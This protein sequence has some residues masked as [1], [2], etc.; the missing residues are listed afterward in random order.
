MKARAPYRF[1]PLSAKIHFPDWADQVS[2]DVPFPDGIVG[3]VDLK[4]VADTPLLVAQDTPRRDGSARGA[5]PVRSFVE[6]DGRVAIPGSTIRG[7]LRNVI[8]IASYGKMGPWIDD[9]RL[10]VRDLHN[11]ALYT[12][13]MTEKR[14]GGYRAKSRAAWLEIGPDGGWQLR[15]CAHARVRIEELEQLYHERRRRAV[16]LSSR[17]SSRSKYLRWGWLEHDLELRFDPTDDERQEE[18]GG[19]VFRRAMNLGTGA[20]VGQIVFTG[21]PSPRHNRK[22]KKR[23]FVFFDDGDEG[24][25]IAVTR[26]QQ[27]DFEWIHSQG[28]R[29]GEPQS[30][31]EWAFFKTHWLG[32]GR[33]VPVFFIP[34]AHGRLA[35]GLAQMFRLPYRLSLHEALD[36]TSTDHRRADPD[37]AELIFG[38]VRGERREALRGRVSFEPFWHD[39]Q[40]RRQRPVDTVLTGPKPSFYP[41]Y[42]SQKEAQGDQTP[43]YATLM[44]PDAELAGWKRYP[45]RPPSQVSPAPVRAGNE[46]VASRLEPLEPGATFMGRLH[47]H[48][49]RPAELGAVLW[50]ITWG[51]R[52]ELRHSLGLGKPFGYGQVRLEV[53][54][55]DLEHVKGTPVTSFDDLISCFTRH[56]EIAVGTWAASEPIAHLLGL[57]DPA[58]GAMVELTH[59]VLDD[60]TKLNE[61]VGIKKERR[62]LPP[63]VEFRGRT[64]RQVHPRRTRAQRERE[65]QEAHDA[66]RRQEEA[67]R[68]RHAALARAAADVARAARPPA[69]RFAEEAQSFD[70]GKA[71]DH[72]KQE[73]RAC[74]SPNER[75]ALAAAGRTHGTLGRLIQ[76]WEAK[77]ATTPAPGTPAFAALAV[78]KQGKARDLLE[79][80]RI[81]RALER[82]DAP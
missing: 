81:L 43:R 39:G 19:L 51:G 7:M 35:F 34:D 23:E 73:I 50:A 10:S 31:E 26:A 8:E 11:H 36:N 75:R 53:V 21:Q 4:L 78:K 32:A 57:A 20:T 60:K 79:R 9:R 71:W 63:L 1:V 17:Q 40:P 38:Y 48:N 77:E 64:D 37:L 52:K 82:G 74:Q 62:V 59:P 80:L 69:E 61:F 56:M 42:V 5:A 29:H 33:R 76:S 70:E 58:R 12:D 27:R 55:H 68:A 6:L 65:A 72:F 54:G 22:A 44:D 66:T 18:D 67:E 16:D 15:P 45:A 24:D 28:E 30:N 47:V 14:D 13:R 25:P 2:H 3:T 49:L 41:Y 46:G